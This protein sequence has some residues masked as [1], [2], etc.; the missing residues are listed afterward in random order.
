MMRAVMEGVTFSLRNCLDVFREMGVE[1][2]E[3]MATGGG[4]RSKVWRQML[5]DVYGCGVS[6]V[7][8]TEGPALGAAILAGVGAGIYG[9]VQEGCDAVIGKNAVQQP[10]AE[11]SSRYEKFYRIYLELYPRL[12]ESFRELASL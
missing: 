11:N 3:M 7:S 10:I 2:D 1:F 6:T 9:S 8:A 4:G 12:K 5:A